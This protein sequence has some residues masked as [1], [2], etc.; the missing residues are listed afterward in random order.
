M[1][2]MFAGHAML[3]GLSATAFI[4]FVGSESF[5]SVVLAFGDSF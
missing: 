4:D 2:Q 1:I 5:A 3:C